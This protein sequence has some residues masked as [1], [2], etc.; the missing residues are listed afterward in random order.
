MDTYARPIA[1]IESVMSEISDLSERLN[2]IYD[3]RLDFIRTG[4]RGAEA[5]EV[6]SWFDTQIQKTRDLILFR[7]KQPTVPPPPETES[8]G[9][10][11]QKETKPTLSLKQIALICYYNDGRITRQNAGDTAK[12]HGH[13]SGE[14]LFHH[15]SYYSSTTN[16]RGDPGTE[17]KLKN[18]IKLFESIAEYLTDKAKLV[19]SDE[20]KTLKTH[21]ESKD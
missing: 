3:Q 16:R 5:N 18:R 15:F 2:Y 20:L 8:Q 19:F 4:H 10:V 1:R 14:A 12:R 13:N 17:R 21:L 11:Q 7:D 6:I 9:E